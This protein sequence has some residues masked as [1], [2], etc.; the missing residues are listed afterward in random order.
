MPVIQDGRDAGYEKDNLHYG[1]DDKRSA[2]LAGKG[3]YSVRQEA[4]EKE[5]TADC[6]PSLSARP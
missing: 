3:D 2:S 4:A 1:P 6:L 5:E